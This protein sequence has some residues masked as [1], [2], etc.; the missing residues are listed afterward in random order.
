MININYQDLIDLGFKRTD[1]NDNVVFK[2]TG[3]HPLQTAQLID[4]I[5]FSIVGTVMILALIL[6]SWYF[7][8]QKDKPD[9]HQ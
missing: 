5:I 4:Q 6:F 9:D 1:Y 2:E 7:I 8:S 3:Y